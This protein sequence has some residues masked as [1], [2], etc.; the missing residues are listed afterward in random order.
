MKD[1]EDDLDGAAITATHNASTSAGYTPPG[2]ATGTGTGTGTGVGSSPLPSLQ[3]PQHY[4]SILGGGGSVAAAPA[5]P[6]SRG[7]SADGVMRAP[8]RRFSGGGGRH[9]V[10]RCGPSRVP[11]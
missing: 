6:P 10:F 5:A 4:N 11:P 2:G 9:L 1:E 3:L 8:G 7:P